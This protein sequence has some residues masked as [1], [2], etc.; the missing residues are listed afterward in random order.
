MLID[1]FEDVA[2]NK[3]NSRGKKSADPTVYLGTGGITYAL[4]KLACLPKSCLTPQIVK[5]EVAEPINIDQENHGMQEEEK[6]P[7]SED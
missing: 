6:R 1:Q 7:A 5:C 2:S 4:H 3:V